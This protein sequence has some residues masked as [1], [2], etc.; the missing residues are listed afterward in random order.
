MFIEGQPVAFPLH[1][2]VRRVTHSA[3]PE[4]RRRFGYYAWRATG[5][6]YVIVKATYGLEKRLDDRPDA[7]L[8]SRLGEILDV[9]SKLAKVA[10][11][12]DAEMARYEAKREAHRARLEETR[13]KEECS[14]RRKMAGDIGSACI[15]SWHALI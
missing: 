2:S 10:S 5:I 14:R 12:K 4:E 11:E 8:E 7:K 3:T 9:A 6:F 15:A 13:R 1:E